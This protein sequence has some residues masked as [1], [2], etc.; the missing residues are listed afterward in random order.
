MEGSIEQIDRRDKASRAEHEKDVRFVLQKRKVADSA[1]NAFLRG[2]PGGVL[3][4]NERESCIGEGSQKV[5]DVL[6]RREAGRFGD[7]GVGGES[8]F[9][10]EAVNGPAEPGEENGGADDA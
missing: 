3:R 9:L 6:G 1:E 2:E 5:A 7:G 10:A 4:R 8:S